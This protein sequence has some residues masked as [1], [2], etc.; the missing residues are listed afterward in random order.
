MALDQQVFILFTCGRSCND[1]FKTKRIAFESSNYQTVIK[2]LWNSSDLF[3]ALESGANVILI[4]YF[5]TGNRIAHC[6]KTSDRRRFPLSPCVSI[7]DVV[8]RPLRLPVVV[9]VVR[10]ARSVRCT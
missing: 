3:E 9:R 6:S 8:A 10:Y 7:A 5:P 2:Q 4:R 1:I